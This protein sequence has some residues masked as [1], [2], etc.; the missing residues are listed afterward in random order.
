MVVGVFLGEAFPAQTQMLGGVEFGGDSHVNIPIAILIWLMI[1]PMM[2]KIDFGGL[3][4]VLRKP[5]GLMIPLSLG[6][7]SRTI[8]I[9][10]QGKDWFETKF[11]PKFRPVTI[12]ALL[13]SLI[14]IFAFQS[15]K[16]F[17]E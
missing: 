10:T 1:Y 9:K 13:A 2:L 12:I 8:L 6:W 15:D 14:F 5:R 4:G 7:M 16:Y 11:L 17:G 3:G